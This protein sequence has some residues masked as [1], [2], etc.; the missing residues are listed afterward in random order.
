MRGYFRIDTLGALSAAR[1]AT[2][3][4]VRHRPRS[5][6]QRA[7]ANSTRTARHSVAKFPGF[8]APLQT[9]DHLLPERVSEAKKVLEGALDQADR[10]IVEGRDA[11]TDMRTIPA[12]SDLAN[13]M[14]VL[15]K[16]LSEEPAAYNRTPIKFSVLVQGAPRTVRPILQDE[17]HRIV[18]E[19]LRNAFRHAQVGHIE[20]EITYGES[21]HL[22]FRD[23]GK[24]IDPKRP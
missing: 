4:G 5:A 21:L 24:G 3:A 9:V 10:A 11:I 12:S 17:M 6:S 14:T 13:S 1:S 15:I 19:S 8:G 2:G 23:D 20:M 18:Q 7:H 22:R 16:S